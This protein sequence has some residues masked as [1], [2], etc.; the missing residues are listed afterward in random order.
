MQQEV[1]KLDGSVTARSTAVQQLR[2]EA[3]QTATRYQTL[4]AGIN[5][6]LQVG[7]T[8]GNPILQSQWNQASTL[9]KDTGLVDSLIEV[10]EGTDWTNQFVDKSKAAVN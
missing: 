1:Q 7:T 10:K 9:F 3:V 2:A 8:P 5:A 4:I 6:R